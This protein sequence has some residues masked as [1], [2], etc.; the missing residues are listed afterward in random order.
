M[1]KLKNSPC[2]ERQLDRSPSGSLQRKAKHVNNYSGNCE[3]IWVKK[4]DSSVTSA[5]QPNLAAVSPKPTPE[6][7]EMAPQRS[8]K[9]IDPCLHSSSSPRSG[10]GS[11]DLKQSRTSVSIQNDSYNFGGPIRKPNGLCSTQSISSL[12][13]FRDNFAQ[14]ELLPL[15]EF[16]ENFANG[17]DIVTSYEKLDVE[18]KT[19]SMNKLFGSW[20]GDRNN[21]AMK[22]PPFK[23][24]VA[25]LN[26]LRMRSN[27]SSLSDWHVNKVGTNN[28][29]LLSQEQVIDEVSMSTP[30]TPY[31]PTMNLIGQNR[32]ANQLFATQSEMNVAQSNPASNEMPSETLL[33]N[34][35]S[36]LILA[37]TLSSLD[38]LGLKKRDRSAHKGQKVKIGQRAKSSSDLS[39][40]SALTISDDFRKISVDKTATKNLS[41]SDEIK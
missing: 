18:E 19:G 25:S 12:D 31:K 22:P 13:S 15:G 11:I 8:Y 29:F 4:S 3:D 1:T 26:S 27:N 30:N 5:S 2:F 35:R 28:R 41:T 32:S 24:A 39:F 21:F 9:L 6:K 40:C 37:E 23:A 16:C 17:V 14:N 38:N 33:K 34:Y 7:T 10:F 20:S 36:E